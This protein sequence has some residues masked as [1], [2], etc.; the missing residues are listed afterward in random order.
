ILAGYLAII[1]SFLMSLF[2]SKP[3]QLVFGTNKLQ[4]L[5]FVHGEDYFL[6][7]DT[8]FTHLASNDEFRE[9]FFEMKDKVLEDLEMNLR[10]RLIEEILFIESQKYERMDAKSLLEKYISEKELYEQQF[11]AQGI[12]SRRFGRIFGRL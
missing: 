3:K 10:N 9:D 7:I 2:E 6:A 12:K 5:S 8:P 4:N 11:K 1:I